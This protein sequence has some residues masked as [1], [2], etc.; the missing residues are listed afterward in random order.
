[1]SPL[2]FRTFLVAFVL[3]CA[4]A[5][6]IDLRAA[7]FTVTST[8]D[9]GAGSLRAAITA[10]NAAAGADTIRF[11]IPGPGL[12]TITLSS[13]L[14]TISGQLLLN[15]YSQS[16]ASTNTIDPGSNAV[17]LIELNG[18]NSVATAINITASNCVIRGLV[19]NRCTTNSITLQ[20]SA[21]NTVIAGNF[22]GTNATG[23]ASSGTGNGLLV[24]SASNVIGG[25]EAESRNLFS[26]NPTGP[27]L[28]FSGTACTDNE[29]ILNQFGLSANG[30][31]TIGGLQEG[32]RADGGSKD[33][34]F[35][36]TGYSFNRITGCTG[37]GVVVVGAAT[38]LDV[39]SSYIWSNGG[40]GIDLN[41]D[42]VTPND[43][44]DLDNGP[45]RLQNHPVITAAMT[46]EDHVVYVNFTATGDP[47]TWH[48]FDFYAALGDPSG[49]GE[50]HLWI[51]A[52]WGQLGSSGSGSFHATAGTWN[53]IPPGTPIT[54]TATN[55]EDASTSEF[56]ANV[57][58]YSGALRVTNISE[59]V[60]G[61]TSSVIDLV[62]S[63]GPDG[64]SLR[65]AV[66]ACNNNVDAWTANQIFF[67]LP[68]SGPNTIELNGPL[69]ALLH[70]TRIL[71]ETDPEFTST[72]V[73]R[74]N[75]SSAGA[76]ANGLTFDTGWGTVSCISITNFSGNGVQF[77]GPN[78]DVQGCHIGVMPD[79]ITCAGNGGAGVFINNTSSC[80]VGDIYWPYI[81]TISGNAGGG[82]VIAGPGAW[83]N[84]VCR[85]RIGTDRAGNTAICTQPVGIELRDGAYGN[86]LG[87]VDPAVGNVISGHTGDGIKGTSPA[88][89]VMHNRIGTDLAG[90]VA[91]PNAMS[92]IDL[93]GHS[94][95]IVNNVISG[96]G[97]RGMILQ[98][99]SCRV[100]G[101]RVGTN[102]A[103]TAALPNVFG[104]IRCTGGAGIAIGGDAATANTISGN[105]QNGLELINTT[106]A[107]VAYDRIGLGSDGA[108][109]IPNTAAGLFLSGASD[110]RVLNNTLAGNLG[111]G[112]Y[113]LNSDRTVFHNNRIG[114]NAAGTSARPNGYTGIT[115][116]HSLDWVVGADAATGNLI[117][118]NGHQ[119][120]YV[121]SG[122]HGGT[123]AGNYIGTDIT[124]GSA[125]PNAHQ[126]VLIDAS[127]NALIGLPDAGNIVSG[128][129][130]DGIVVRAGA[131]GCR[132]RSNRVGVRADG[133]AALPNSGEGITLASGATGNTIGGSATGEG[134]I[135]AGNTGWGIHLSEADA[136]T[137]AG[138]RIGVN[139]SGA[140]RANLCGVMV[141]A[142]D[143]NIIGGT[144]AASRNI[145]SGNL[146]Y[147]VYT[148]E[149][150]AGNHIRGNHI[151][152]DAAG[153]TAIG[154]GLSGVKIRDGLNNTVGGTTP[155]HGNVISGNGAN[156]VEISRNLLP[157][158]GN[159]VQNNRIGTNATGTAALGNVYGVLVQDNA[160]TT[161]VR[162]NLISGNN[163]H[164]IVLQNVSG[165]QV[166][167]NLIGTDAG[168]NAPLG[169]GQHG[170][171][172]GLS[173]S[174]NLIGGTTAAD[175]N[176]IGANT[177]S[178]VN[179]QENAADNVI[180][181]NHIG[182]G[183]DGT[184]D[185]GNHDHGIHLRTTSSATRI[186]GV[187]AGAG[188]TISGNDKNGI[189]IERNCTGNVLGNLIGTSA[190]GLN[191]RGNTRSG[192]H[193][194]A[195]SWTIG[196]TAS[197]AGNTISG[198]DAHGI[199]I[200]ATTG[201]GSGNTIAGNRI[202]T[203][204]GGTGSIANTLNGVR[205][206]G[207]SN[208]IGGTV[209]GSANTIAGNT[210]HGVQVLGPGTGNLIATNAIRSNGGLGIELNNDGQDVNDAGDGDT[211]A[212]TKQ[213]FPVL[214]N[215]SSN[216]TTTTVQGSINT[217]PGSDVRIEFFSNPTGTI[218]PSGY[219]EGHTYIGSTTV[220]T[221][222][223]GNAA[224]S[225]LLPVPVS[226]GS[227][228][229]SNATRVVSGV[230]T[231]TSEFSGN[232]LV[233]SQVNVSGT[234]FED[235]N[236]GGGAGRDR[237]TAL[238][239]GGSGR[240]NA[241]VELFNSSGN[242]VAST[243]TDASGAYVFSS[244]L[245]G[246][247][248]V[249]VVNGTVSSAR[250]GYVAGS[251]VPVQTFRTHVVAGT[252]QPLTDRVGGE[253]PA[254]AD[255][256]NGT[257]T[258]AALATATTSAQSITSVNVSGN[259]VT[260]V[261]FGY[262]FSVICNTN[263]AGQGSLRQFIHQANVL[264][265]TGLAIQG[266]TAGMEH[267]IFMI[268]NGTAA[269]GLRAANNSFSGGV[270]TIQPSIFMTHIT[271][272][273]VLDAQTQPGWTNAPILELNGNGSN[274]S[275]LR[276]TTG[277][278]GSVLRGFVIG[279]FMDAG[280][281]VEG[282][283]VTVQG[284]Y[285]GTDATGTSARSN[286]GAGIEVLT[287]GNCLI[288]GSTSTTRNIISGNGWDGILC[289]GCTNSTIM[290]NRIGTN[291]TGTA[292][293]PNASNG[294]SL[295]N[296]N[297][298]VI[299]TNGD[300]T[301]DAAEGN[302][303]SGNT[304]KGIHVGNSPGTVIAGNLIGTDITATADLGNTSN[305]IGLD[306]TSNCR[307][308][309]N[310]DG[311]SDVLERNIISGNNGVGINLA[312][313]ST[314][315]CVIAGNHIGT[316]GNGTAALG[317]T[318][319]GLFFISNPNG[320]RVGTNGDG[321]NDA[322]EANLIS[323]NSGHGIYLHNNSNNNTIAG[324]R[325]GTDVTGMSALP[326]TSG[327]YIQNASSP[328]NTIGGASVAFGNL[329]AGNTGA[330]VTAAGNGT[331]VSHNWVGLKSDGTALPNGGGGVNVG[332]S[333]CSVT[334]N[335]VSGNTGFG[336]S[337]TGASSQVLDNLVGTD[338]TGALARP[339]TTHGI[340]LQCSDG[341]IQ[342][343]TISGNTSHGLS[344][345]GGSGASLATITGNRIGITTGG[346]PLGN[347]GHGILI[348][349]PA[350]PLRIGGSPAGEANTIAN[351]TGDGLFMSSGGSGMALIRA[352]AIFNNG[353][354]GIDLGVDGVTVNDPNDA[355]SGPNNLQNFPLLGAVSSAGGT[356][357]INGT[358]HSTAS[359][360]FRIEFFS[361]PTADPTGNGEGSTYLGSTTVT[362]DASGNASVNTTLSGVSLTTGHVVSSTATNTAINSTS[363]FSRA[364]TVTLPPIAICQS[365][366]LVLSAS[367]TATL[368]PS[369]V[370]GGS[371]DPDGTIAGLSVSQTLFTCAH[372]GANTVTL[373]VTDNSGA[374]ATCT[375]TVTVVDNINPVINN[376]PGNITLN[377]GALCNAVATWTAPTVSDNCSGATITRT[378]GPATG[379]TFPVGSTFITYTATDAA[380]NQSTCTFNVVVQDATAPVIAG[381]PGNITLNA[382][383]ACNAVATWTA[384]SVSDNCSGATITRTAGPASGS[385]FPLGSTTVTYT[386]TDA[387]GRTA[388]CSFMVTV[389]DATGPVINCPANIVVGNTANLCGAVVNY[390]APVGTDNCSGA[391]TVRLAGPASG[392]T[393]P[394]GSTT[395][396]HRVTD[397]AGLQATCSF[398]VTVTDNEP[399]NA[400]CQSVNIGLNGSGVANLTPAQVNNGSTDNCGI[401]AM[402][403]VPNSF[404]A[405]GNHTVTLTVTDA[406][407]NSD[408]CTVDITVADN[409]AP[410]AVCNN[411]TIH[412]NAAGQ[413]TVTGAMLNGGSTDNG[414]IVSLTPSQTLFDCSD[415]GPNNV[416]LTVADDG[417]NA[418]VCNAVVT[419]LDTIRPQAACHPLIVQLDATGHVT[420][421][422]SDIEN[423]SSDNCSVTSTTI[424]R[425]SFDCSDLGANTV[426]LTVT[427]GSGISTTCT[428]TVTVE[429]P[430]A[431]TILCPDD[432]VM[433]ND[434]G[435]CGAVVNYILPSVSDNCSNTLLTCTSGPASGSAFPLGIT[436]VTYQATD[437]AGH[438]ASCSF[439]VTVTDTEAP[440]AV[441]QSID[442]GLDGLGVATLTPQQIDG[443][444]TDNC[445][446]D[447]MV[448]SP[449][450]FTATGGHD[451]TLTVFDANGNSDACTVNITVTDGLAPT[452]LCN[453]TILHLDASGQVTI[454]PDDIDGGSHD[455]GT[456]VALSASQTAFDCADLGANAV[457]LTV[458][459][460]NG[461]TDQCTAIVTV[462]DTIAPVAV[463]QAI[464]VQLDINGEATISGVDID[465]GSTD[466]CG[467]TP[468]YTADITSFQSTGTFE[469]TLTVTDASGNASSCT[470]SVTVTNDEPP[471]AICRN[472]TA[473][474]DANGIAS[475][476]VTDID[477]GSTAEGPFSLS[478]SRTLFGCEDIGNN[479][480]ILTMTDGNGATD[481]CTAIVT[482]I[483]TIAPAVVC[484]NISITL[485]GNGHAMI[486]AAELDG[487]STDNCGISGMEVSI[488]EFD[489]A[490]TFQVQF[491]IT[492]A[493]GNTS[494]CTAT[495]NV[496]TPSIKGPVVI[497]FGFSPNGDGIAD[498]WIIRGVDPEA[499]VQVEVFNRWGDTVH[500]DSDYR[501]DWD[502]TCTRG[503]GPTGALPDG[504]Y[505]FVVTIAD[506][507]PVT[508]YLQI[509]R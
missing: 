368:P 407:G 132:I 105:G 482:V 369:L 172:I 486:V 398:T 362:T 217:T 113:V 403:V 366:T 256:G 334:N 314:T 402:S 151:G 283:D 61:N 129:A 413:A 22:L 344:I 218:D 302:L 422:A 123:A 215:A 351:N 325:I 89:T 303:I 209:T 430:I 424:D 259:H 240:P 346:A 460:D 266:R 274:A 412:L 93:I 492:D 332:G 239:N 448:V 441:C 55:D 377:A 269:P 83:A 380:G 409:N 161:I 45:N 365:A 276:F 408:A 34:R 155:A 238:A 382:G 471:M 79:G 453:D 373:T 363:E 44:G 463:C 265:N 212:N 189:E 195:N 186:G 27:G 400:I 2:P 179:L 383:A 257:T 69:P 49:H 144:D 138:N 173:A 24:L 124:G 338:P 184:T 176:V 228:I 96:N 445:G 372:V 222:A 46:D 353:G 53:N 125:L 169:N 381:C 316:N 38:R 500:A 296:A 59:T 455:N 493:A 121:I 67:D 475:I 127:N 163:S 243:T 374:T 214:A 193:L 108:T 457:V 502:G 8:A 236:Y 244:T 350:A 70:P 18:N 476:V 447:S 131:T 494:T 164:G 114:T 410:T 291:A 111:D 136:N 319:G 282:N 118:G 311:I 361:S 341:L 235:V 425:N 309:T 211:G 299:G 495:V 162:D 142:S 254:L 99:D 234:V 249:R 289:T 454:T 287:A 203:N 418:D 480:V 458:T 226:I 6:P 451:V 305:G 68:G 19:I 230:P 481:Q 86:M 106:G 251:H 103:G 498:T 270:A 167:G 339:N 97:W 33:N 297:N 267:A 87:A 220:T 395:V 401:T 90:S 347:G 157:T 247:Y 477:G 497:P 446:I 352:N 11:N 95:Y 205:M 379:S 416:T 438:Q 273:L 431:P 317:N 15:G 367:G 165:A 429:D 419:V 268:G 149:N 175:R 252:A 333:G 474:L 301:N 375:A 36:T 306:N 262:S 503:V 406:A 263:D 7:T 4:I 91:I 388:T 318:G 484:R 146:E 359:T 478:A 85:S 17:L 43:A 384:P 290:G 281:E 479:P 47:N 371:T 364:V 185:I 194:S 88:N 158:S 330:G 182:V 320:N 35:G 397:A 130:Q 456:I 483:D 32:V 466:N 340:V 219:G 135:V 489:S 13:T 9:A 298:V 417:G 428:A 342:G 198:N 133:D 450:S 48:R 223:G 404:T 72:P 504:T 216:A 467:G 14:P 84:Q 30:T 171:W 78:S 258:L 505:F 231:S 434:P 432:I 183:A 293:I 208:V 264:S 423:G 73:V 389:N 508:G 356:T 5:Q 300:G 94:S 426:L 261:D 396:T 336:I 294:V 41:N 345:S 107:I 65:E 288:G 199:D 349:A 271:A 126:G 278:N 442:I 337:V 468:T 452:A 370:D 285:I 180:T 286:G 277:A 192:I 10:A 76:G 143:N 28:R 177:E 153:T 509:A 355:D 433:D 100:H 491:T 327:I 197:G 119:G 139:A 210:Q 348:N 499:S 260:G 335:V 323:G 82:V 145:I 104:G 23:T 156:G 62:G 322:L 115:I 354:L 168:G 328:N 304:S 415:L 75:G 204:S 326:N 376:C 221:D 152:T 233:V 112:A 166:K 405:I 437:A 490:G 472:D 331:V 191:D 391:T 461:N 92:G 207:N 421:T 137:V 275:G 224:F 64:I 248:T 280:V 357:T 392:S 31:T 487:G 178:G 443:G 308:G 37:A 473:Y 507:R 81:N 414:T 279:R 232:V 60:N 213:N 40:L 501:N 54:M 324:N 150:S 506:Q 496:E 310:A 74:I 181:G 360:P 63:P 187:L 102:S 386:A 393:F 411:V 284:C 188:N 110:T 141:E 312:S 98:G 80:R 1:M 202:G 140:A 253:V 117:S 25:Y 237:A 229:T 170:I 255:A 122:S 469:V 159:A 292:A 242:L 227:R 250:T 26:G 315:G 462:I 206:D 464:T 134:N 201:G 313:A 128:N 488:A 449:N 246:N 116:E 307:I 435:I 378:A 71:G 66:M 101:N 385:T 321:T 120:L 470:A 148:N 272:P 436:T 56:A 12:R 57:A 390:P 387:A 459:D 77:N 225:A 196:G 21:T 245:P 58:C 329:I 154:N 29:V 52:R 16:G 440:N 465:G 3:L 241:R 358:L 420:I 399:P 343:N 295:L 444:S 200:D 160:A 20:S 51:G 147:G 439:T 39:A 42:G 394:I 427:D 485:D 174:N 190:D 50:G 109:V